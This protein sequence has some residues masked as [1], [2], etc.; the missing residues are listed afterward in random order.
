MKRISSSAAIIAVAMIGVLS[1]SDRGTTDP[2]E[3]SANTPDA[4]VSVVKVTLASDSLA[5]AQTTQATATLFNRNNTQVDRT[6]VWSSSNPSIATV[7]STGV[8][9]ARAAG[10]AQITATRLLVSGS[11]TVTVSSSSTA[12]VAS[13]TVG[14]VPA[15]ISTGQSTQGTAT[16][17][18]ANN[19]V[20][21]GRAI[22]WKSSNTA[23]ATITQSGVAPAVAAGTSQITAT[24]E[25]QVGGAMLTV[26]AAPP[27]P[28]G[29]NEPSGMTAI[30]D[31]PFN[32]LDEMGWS[33]G[34]GT[35]GKII[36]DATAPKSPS[37][38]LQIKLPAGFGE[39]GGP[40][41]G[42]LQLPKNYRTVYISY[43]AKYS[44]NWYGPSSNINKTFYLYTSTGNPAIVF[45]M[46]CHAT[47]PMETQVAGQD[48]LKGGVGGDPANPF[49]TPNLAS[50]VVTRGQW[51]HIEFVA[52]GNTSGNAD[53][54][55]DWYLNG[56]HVGSYKGI[57]FQSGNTLWNLMHYTLLYTGTNNS[58]PPA[59][60]YNYWDQIYLSG[61]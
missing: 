58:N 30:S 40:F 4:I 45:D 11:A 16:L 35:Y 21:T 34:S 48:I 5:L 49:W 23:V 38:V 50:G 14:L 52:V 28:P 55:I 51:H 8:V 39:G 47:G 12:P 22:T 60:Q 36:S 61:K 17:R 33:D 56:V 29:S 2:V 24:A 7:S 6:V 32:A 53:G 31:R 25:G 57:Q 3:A 43:W 42:E 18:D 59:D 10:V 20:V 19:N 41:S 9:R 1:C 54:S 27:P 13:V 15:T 44:S 46:D 26:Q 37:N